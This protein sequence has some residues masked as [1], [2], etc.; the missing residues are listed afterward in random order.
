MC[1]YHHAC[2]NY[3]NSVD[4]GRGLICVSPLGAN[5]GKSN[6]ILNKVLGNPS[7]LLVGDSIHSF[8]FCLLRRE[9][10]G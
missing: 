2:V 5:S 8:K 10:L 1:V 7:V 6:N 3:P 4:E 9:L